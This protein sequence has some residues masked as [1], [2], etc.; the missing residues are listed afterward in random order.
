MDFKIE[1]NNIPKAL[2]ESDES[3]TRALEMIGLKAEKYAKALAPV[4]TP[5]STGI[6]GYIGGTLRNSITHQVRASERAVHIGTN[7]DYAPYV[8][9]GTRK[10]A[11][12]P[13]IVPAIE[14]HTAEY[15]RIAE[16]E[17][18]R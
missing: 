6:K 2:T 14:D 4:G 10:M 1:E 9:L 5:E 8:E 3:V 7:V 13:Y 12:R 18:K 16:Q 11:K 15:K 17:L